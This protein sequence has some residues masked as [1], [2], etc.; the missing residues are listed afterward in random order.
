MNKIGAVDSDL[1]FVLP[2]FGQS[3]IPCADCAKVFS[4][5]LLFFSPLPRKWESP[6][7]LVTSGK[8]SPRGTSR[9]QSRLQ[10]VTFNDENEH[11]NPVCSVDGTNQPLERLFFIPS[12]NTACSEHLSCFGDPSSIKSL[13]YY[14][15]DNI[16]HSSIAPCEEPSERFHPTKHL[17]WVHFSNHGAPT[18]Y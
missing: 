3:E 18:K 12:Y 17:F 11:K 16:I 14:F 1:G 5:P 6:P 7:F 13:E 15:E 9:R 2:T 4:T 10:S 8:V